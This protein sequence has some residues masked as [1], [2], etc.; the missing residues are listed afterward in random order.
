MSESLHP[1]SIGL[2]VYNGERYLPNAIEALLAQTFP[3]F[4]LIL[5]DNA[6]TDATEQICRSYVA[7][8]GRVRYVRNAKNLG[9]SLNFRRAF[10]LARGRYFKWAC[11]D[12]LCAPEFL[13]RCVEVLDRDP[14]VVLA[15]PK[16]KLIDDNGDFVSE[17][18][19]HLHLPFASPF[20][21]FK[22]I[23]ERMGL[24]N[25]V[26]GLIR[27]DALKQTNLFGNFIANDNPLLVEL[28][29][30]GKFC[31]VPE[32]LFYRRFHKASSSEFQNAN[33][34]LS[35]LGAGGKR[36]IAMTK[37]RHLWENFRAVVRAPL[38]LSE[39]RRLYLHLVRRGVWNRQKL[40]SE[41][42]AAAAQLIRHR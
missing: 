11:Y 19:D 29:L 21:R 4:E 17:Y 25:P 23:F 2:P 13:K 18:Q 7:R 20:D 14:S 6:S 30:Y 15:Y 12:D 39:K 42:T 8:D 26:Y 40:M 35:Y 36:R 37:W 38:G 3:N 16:T 27:S 10:E 33:Q 31:E 22:E 41:L 1:V 34:L 24:C 32:F 9:I 5:C 28:T